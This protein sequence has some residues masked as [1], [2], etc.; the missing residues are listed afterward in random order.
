MTTD[1]TR[2]DW[3]L[4]HTIRAGL[5]AQGLRSEPIP[6][7]EFPQA[8]Q[9][10]IL[11]LSEALQLD[12]LTATGLVALGADPEFVS[13][14]SRM[15]KALLRSMLLHHV[16]HQ[17]ETGFQKDGIQ[18]AFFKGILSDNL[19]WEQSGMRGASDID[20]LVDGTD[21]EKAFNVMA[22]IGA[23]EL[24]LG[25]MS[26][27][28]R[29]KARIFRVS[30]AAHDVCIDLHLEL[31]ARDSGAMGF[32]A[33]LLSRRHEYRT[34]FGDIWGLSAE[35]HLVFIAANASANSYASRFKSCLDVVLLLEQE[36]LDEEHLLS[37]AAQWGLENSLWTILMLVK[38]RFAAPVSARLLSS[39][40]ASAATRFLG[41]RIAGVYDAPLY[42]G[43]LPCTLVF[44]DKVYVA[45]QTFSKNVASRFLAS[46]GRTTQRYIL[47]GSRIVVEEP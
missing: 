41:A 2:K 29:K 5:C 46:V 28:G 42:V 43:E 12:A 18:Y 13:V 9:K 21:Q 8:I 37:L 4:S 38:T 14:D 1:A 32:S 6:R 44:E 35:D 34:K 45:A 25:L 17:M 20:L 36:S 31:L 7:F 19:W 39:L 33:D 40:R 11:K 10:E 47:R 30:I 22:K 23:K 24:Q 26:E 27:I 16:R 3:A 15:E